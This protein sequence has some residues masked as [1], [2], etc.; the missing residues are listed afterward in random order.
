MEEENSKNII[1]MA[2]QMGLRVVAKGVE[3]E[4]QL[5]FLK[6]QMCDDL[7]GDLYYAAMPANL[8]KKL[9][10]ISLSQK[11]QIIV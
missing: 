5:S 7:Q 3:T 10:Q 2:K 9:I 8:T 6:K 1:E 11:D 4:A